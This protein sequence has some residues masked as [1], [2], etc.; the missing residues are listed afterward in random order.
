VTA[1]ELA[2][3]RPLRR[4]EQAI[5]IVRLDQALQTAKDEL[6]DAIQAEML[7]ATTV[8]ANGGP[9]ALH[10]TDAMLAPLDDLETLGQTEARKEL[11]RLGYTV[12]RA[13]ERK[14][15]EFPDDRDPAAYLQRNLGAIK[16]RIEQD[17]TVADLSG[18]ASDAIARALLRVPG[19]RDIASR[20]VSTAL[21]NGLAQTFDDAA[22][23]VGGWEYTAVLDGGECDR[24]RPLD[25]T[26]YAS[27]D[28]LFAVLPN[29]GPNPRCLG[30]GRCR[31]R[32][33]PLPFG[34]TV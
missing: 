17:L 22:D 13:L 10:V 31:C 29:F 14:I 18:L 16:I 3:G 19:G 15:E 34:E 4:A 28:E 20:I 30:G 23:L 2:V 12:P 11:D 33:V 1:V 24:C 27:V 7:R 8:W 9:L 25:G 26:R 32:A 21:I 5:D 6:D